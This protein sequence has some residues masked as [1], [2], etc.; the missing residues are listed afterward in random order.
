VRREAVSGAKPRWLAAQACRA[1]LDRG[2]ALDEAFA[3]VLGEVEDGRDRSLVRRLANGVMRDW[4]ALDFLVRELLER[5]MKAGDRIV[6]FLLAVAVHELRDGREPEHA[7]VHA[8]VAAAAGV[9]GG[10]LRGLVN[11]VLRNFLRRRD[12][13]EAMVA[14]DPARSRGYPRWLIDRIETDW[15][16]EAGSILAAGNRVPPLWLRVNRRRWSR[17]QALDVLTRAGF[18]AHLPDGFADAV[19]LDERVRVSKLPGIAE[20]ALSVQDGAA[21]LVVD[22][23]ELADGQRVLDACAAP[24]GK[25]AHILERAEVELT[26]LDIDGERL[27]RVGE[28]L[29]R[30]GCNAK[31]KV[32]NAAEPGTWWDGRLFDRVLV[33][34]PCSATGV[35]RR[36]PDVRWLRRP[37]DV[38]ALVAAQR[39][40]LD[41]LWPLLK[42]GGILVYATCSVLVVENA[43]Q[44]QS[45]LERHADARVIEHTELPGRSTGP[46]RQL[47]PGDE[48]CDGFF[49]LAARRLQ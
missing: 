33:D 16:A 14:E 20:G 31:L 42:P 30:L 28:N 39:A 49:S 40:M 27:K 24:G 48:D 7:V 35:I 18:R 21:Q 25:S 2:Q 1:V 12:A 17:E 29:E 43:G 44:V 10:R 38:E 26:A 8:A 47:L 15:P 19:M 46:G 37:S 23:L 6:F 9:R 36:H 32:G 41:A 11:A 45:F 34:A 3:S 13:L 4:P 22:E 5:P